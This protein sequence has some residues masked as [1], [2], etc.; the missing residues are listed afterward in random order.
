MTGLLLTNKYAVSNNFEALKNYIFDAAKNNNIELSIYNNVEILNLL[1]TQKIKNFD[2]VLFW[3]KDV[4]LAMYLES[5][6]LKVFNSSESIRLCDDKSLT[7][8]TLL[9]KNIV[10]PKTIFSPLIY[11]HDISEDEE[12]I[13]I[14]LSNFNFP[15][16]FKECFGSFGEQVYLI[17]NK[18]EL[19]NRIKACDVWPFIVQEFI[20][21]SFGKDLRVYIVG[22]KIVGAIKRE[23]KSGDF[24]A[25]VMRGGIASAY[26]LSEAEKELAFK[27]KNALKLDFC[28]VDIL[29]GKNNVP[30]LCEVNSNAYFVGLNRE[31]KINVADYIFKYIMGTFKKEH[32]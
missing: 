8:I 29:F 10:Q 1:L 13:D 25:N 7:Y 20:E 12:F 17:N 14:I 2:F 27:A 19:V 23:N 31:L 21:E 11:Y 32:F 4:K 3:D 9:N 28:G 30:I 18:S 16:I 6:G 24:R 26:S 15:F 22:D 5:I